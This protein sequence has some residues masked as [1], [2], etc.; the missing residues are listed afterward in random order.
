MKD[1][2]IKLS[3]V[4]D[5]KKL[6]QITGTFSSDIDIQS[7]RYVIDAKSIMGVFSLDLSKE[8]TLRIMSEDIDEIEN[9]SNAI[10]PFKL[11]ISLK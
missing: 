2:K 5:V 6:V 7:S 3:N 10:E 4:D 9:F 11:K 8:L 1:F